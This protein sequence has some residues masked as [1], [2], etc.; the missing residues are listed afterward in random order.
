MQIIFHKVNY[1]YLVINKTIVVRS[2]IFY[3]LLLL[4]ASGC[5]KDRKTIYNVPEEAEVLVQNF[6][7]EGE[8][9]GMN[10]D[11]SNLVVEF[12]K[13][14]E[15]ENTDYC[16]CSHTDKNGQLVVW[17][18]TTTYCWT[19]GAYYREAIL[20]HELGHA[21]LNRGHND[22]KLP[23]GSW[24]SLMSTGALDYYAVDSLNYRRTY[25]L[26]ELFMDNTPSPWWDK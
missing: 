13:N 12:K 20:F 15:H 9:R 26:D 8:A 23:K 14:I 10:V 18:D 2:Y 21:L 3:A 7:V 11:I 5:A 22:Q 17:I 16:G 19:F 4:I 25:Y 24:K 1:G 6:V